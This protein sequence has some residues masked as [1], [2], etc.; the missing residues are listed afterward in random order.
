MR[1]CCVSH[2]IAEPVREIRW[3]D[4]RVYPSS[5]TVCNAEGYVGTLAHA[6][7]EEGVLPAVRACTLVFPTGADVVIGVE[8]EDVCVWVVAAVFGCERRCDA[9]CEFR[10]REYWS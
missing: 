8:V 7:Y 2:V 4:A 5:N 6:A 3:V 10:V 1:V 9:I